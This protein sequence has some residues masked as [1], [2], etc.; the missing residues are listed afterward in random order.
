MRAGMLE[1]G[2]IALRPGVKELVS[3]DQFRG[4]VKE[5]PDLGK[6]QGETSSG[7]V[8]KTNQLNDPSY[9]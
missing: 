8:S 5:K 7:E 3:P 2:K 6:G 9:P 4:S 1:E